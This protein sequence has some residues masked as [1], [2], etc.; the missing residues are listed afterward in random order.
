VPSVWYIVPYQAGLLSLSS[1]T[2]RGYSQLCL[3]SIAG[4]W[5]ARSLLLV[6]CVIGDGARFER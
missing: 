1:G 3:V 2:K 4:A 6:G 5:S